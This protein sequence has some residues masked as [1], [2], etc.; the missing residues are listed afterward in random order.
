MSWLATR[1]GRWRAGRR[2][3][4]A[5]DSHFAVS[6]FGPSRFGASR[7]PVSRL[8]SAASAAARARQAR[9]RRWSWAGA[10]TGAL[11]AVLLYAPATWLASAVAA[12]SGERV[13]LAQARGTV[14]NG[15]AV[16]VLSG[17]PGS[18]DATALPGRL[19][20]RL[21]P[22]GL[23]VSVRLSQACCLH[24]EVGL[25]V[26]AGWS[27]L[28]VQLQ[29]PPDWAAQW[30][31]ALLGGLGTPWNTLQLGGVLRLSSPGLTLESAAGR[32]LVQGRADLDILDAS[33]PLVTLS[34]L[35]SYR[36]S[37]F[38]NEQGQVQIVLSTREGALQLSGD[39][40]WGP[41]GVRFRGEARASEGFQDA[42]DNLLNIIG[43]RDGA[44]SVISIG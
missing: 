3:T 15:D 24:G 20:W 16:L 29:A 42:L 26:R 4:D 22:A 23:G 40:L 13:L 41:S 11:L 8:D 7:F 21:R 2:R 25:R 34:Q 31:S 39:G 33:S 17:G 28:S 10:L 6:Q 38:S 32:W 27:R 35:G 14:W 44:R 19:H 43:R 9:L 18:R 36:L 12:A 1:L 37:L 30:P 5:R